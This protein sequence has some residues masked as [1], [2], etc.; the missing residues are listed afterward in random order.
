M[1]RK[2]R[3]LSYEMG[4]LDRA[5]AEQYEKSRNDGGNIRKK[6]MLEM[7]DKALREGLTKKQ[8]YCVNA[9]YLEGRDV[10]QIAQELEISSATVY[11][12]LSR[13]RRR[14][15]K[16]GEYFFI[17]LGIKKKEDETA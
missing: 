1:L 11:R 6:L 17:G 10:H 5:S 13:G 4:L 3:V 14:M 8:Q 15:K 16:Y 12:H 9:Y 7:V 2:N